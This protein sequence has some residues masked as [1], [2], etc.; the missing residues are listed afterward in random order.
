MVGARIGVSR[1]L[2]VWY[3]VRRS[4]DLRPWSKSS[5]VNS[6]LVSE[7]AGCV[8][9]IEPGAAQEGNLQF[10]TAGKWRTGAIWSNV[11]LCRSLRKSIGEFAISMKEI[12]HYVEG[13]YIEDRLWEEAD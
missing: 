12:L 2:T 4:S 7:F 3:N 10:R 5:P 11:K 9:P 6:V 1:E 8:D 13:T